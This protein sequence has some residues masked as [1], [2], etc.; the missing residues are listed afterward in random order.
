MNWDF[1]SGITHRI[2]FGYFQGY[3][4]F[5]PVNLLY[6][7]AYFLS[8]AFTHNIFPMVGNYLE[9]LYGMVAASR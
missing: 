6:S 1:R 3:S 7:W 4:Y 9:P 2:I 5:V 8:R